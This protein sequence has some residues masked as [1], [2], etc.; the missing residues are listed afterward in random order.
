MIMRHEIKEVG[1]HPKW[2]GPSAVAII[3][4]RTVN[5]CAKKFAEVQNISRY[6]NH[7]KAKTSRMVKGVYGEETLVVLDRLGYEIENV[8]KLYRGMTL[9]QYIQQQSTREM[10]SMVLINV[11]RHYVV[12]NMGLISDNHELAR[13]VGAHQAW[14]KKIQHVYIVKRKRK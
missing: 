4:S 10:K 8:S 3:T 13:P 1:T 12:A 7:R 6:R 5:Y 11:T 2:C 14:R 9:N